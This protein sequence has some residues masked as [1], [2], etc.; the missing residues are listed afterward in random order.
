MCSSE[1]NELPESVEISAGD[2]RRGAERRSHDSAPIQGIERRTGQGRRPHEAP[3]RPKNLLEPRDGNPVLLV[4]VVLSRI[5]REFA[6]VETDEELGRLHVG[7]MIEEIASQVEGSRVN[8][9]SGRLRHLGQ[10]Q[11]HAVYVRCGDNPTSETVYLSTVLIPGDPIKSNYESG[12]HAE[13]SRHLLQ[14]FARAI[15]YKIA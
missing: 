7:Q 12:R 2:R 10:A 4:P 5:Q 15:G 8:S 11:T 13:D 1:V 3:A 9:E 6:Y 14:R